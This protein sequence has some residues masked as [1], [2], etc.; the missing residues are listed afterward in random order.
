MHA[1]Q[2]IST[3]LHRRV[4]TWLNNRRGRSNLQ[5][6]IDDGIPR[7]SNL[8]SSAAY[9][10]ACRCGKTFGSPFFLSWNEQFLVVCAGFKG[11]GSSMMILDDE[12]IIRA[13]EVFCYEYSFDNTA[14]IK[15]VV[16]MKLLSYKRW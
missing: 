15:I 13:Y 3:H 11:N 10:F 5:R 16:N 8:A 7:N 12:C 1:G 9:P 14:L 4:P 6:P 2:A